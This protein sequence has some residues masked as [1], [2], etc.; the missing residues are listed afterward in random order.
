MHIALYPP[1][2]RR[3]NLAPPCGFLIAGITSE[4]KTFVKA[5]TEQILLIDATLAA[6]EYTPIS[7]R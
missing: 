2:P 3:I 6:A 5:P 1:D 4:V 7:S